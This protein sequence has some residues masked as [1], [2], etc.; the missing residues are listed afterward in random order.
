[1][2]LPLLPIVVISLCGLAYHKKATSEKGPGKGV[3]TAE[4]QTAYETAIKECTD[5]GK[6]RTLAQVFRDQGLSVQADMLEKRAALRDMPKEVKE[7]RRKVYK[8]AMA[9]T[10]PDAIRNL[11][12]A[13]ER[14]GCYGAAANLRKYAASLPPTIP[15]ETQ[16]FKPVTPEAPRVVQQATPVPIPIHGDDDES[17]P[18]DHIDDEKIGDENYP[19]S[20]S[21]TAE[22]NL[23][24]EPTDSDID[25]QNQNQ[26]N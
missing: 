18:S 19:S 15:G 5:A 26:E 11:A 7:A 8:K 23:P 14:E 10:N 24:E 3:L 20:D 9:S 1:M 16:G 21:L 2:P 4:R 25:A 12:I 22:E 6:L 17:S 13:Y